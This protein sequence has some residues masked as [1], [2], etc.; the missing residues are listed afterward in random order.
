MYQASCITSL[1]TDRQTITA[2]PASIMRIHPYQRCA[3]LCHFCPAVTS[4][5]TASAGCARTPLCHHS[6]D[7]PRTNV[8]RA[9]H[10][11]LSPAQGTH[12]LCQCYQAWAGSWPRPDRGEYCHRPA[13]TRALA[14][15][16]A[17]AP[18]TCAALQ[19]SH[20]HA[21][22]ADRSVGVCRRLRMHKQVLQR[23]PQAK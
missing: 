10:I 1:K 14:V 21:F 5:S 12:P 11:D 20:V 16:A 2:S 8:T 4:A 6:C 7:D 13:S 9:V 3:G 17:R 19:L 15:A 18:H 23:L 22:P